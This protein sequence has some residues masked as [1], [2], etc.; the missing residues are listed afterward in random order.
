MQL[1]CQQF[2]SI[3]EIVFAI[4]FEGRM[5]A[6]HVRRLVSLLE[7]QAKT[8]LDQATATR[9]K[10]FRRLRV[11]MQQN[12]TRCYW[13]QKRLVTV[14]HILRDAILVTLMKISELLISFVMDLW[15][16]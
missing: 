11:E 5:A 15:S 14:R 2:C 16:P 1:S 4:G 10:L 12:G 6:E 8:C 3:N 13:Y 7:D 9:V